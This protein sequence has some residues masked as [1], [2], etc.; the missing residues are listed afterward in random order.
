MFNKVRSKGV[1]I[2]PCAQKVQDIPSHI[3]SYVENRI[4]LP[5]NAFSTLQIK[6]IRT[7]ATHFRKNPAFDT[8]E[9]MKSLTAGQVLISPVGEDR[10]P[11]PVKNGTILPPQSST[12]PVSD[13]DIGNYLKNN[14]LYRSL[15]SYLDQICKD[16]RI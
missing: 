3:L 8:F 14:S 15:P 1:G 2:W 16:V 6:E 9:V 7:T 12:E 13:S 10:H 4:Q 11:F 5:P